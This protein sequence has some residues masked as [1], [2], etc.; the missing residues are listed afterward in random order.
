MAT[1]IKSGLGNRI[2]AVRGTLSRDAFEK[3]SGISKNSLGR[4]ERDE[5][6]PGG[7]VI[8]LI[9][10]KCAVS[11]YWLLF[12]EGPMQWGLTSEAA[13]SEVLNSVQLEGR[14]LTQE[15]QESLAENRLLRRER[16]D[17]EG[18]L[19]EKAIDP[20]RDLV[21]SVLGLAECSMRG[22][23]LQSATSMFAPAPADIKVA[24]GFAVIAT[25]DSMVPAGILPG[26]VIFCNPV[27]MPL[28]GDIVY[29]ERPDGYATIKL[30]QGKTK[31]A[32][33]EFIKLKGWLPANPDAP[34]EPQ[35]PYTDEFLKD[36]VKRVAVVVY[37]RRRL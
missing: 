22:W 12:D 2:R 5:M 3:K 24:D 23:E 1:S 27:I 16:A 37:I 9:C 25:G 36:Q 29:V 8:A 7:D 34:D 17:L 19:L 15:L 31:R 11:P 14:A 18:K 21:V 20:E 6:M 26:N 35:K 32:G 28:E 33:K 13:S 4:Y 10:T 30:W